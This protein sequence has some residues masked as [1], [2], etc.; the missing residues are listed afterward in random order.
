MSKFSPRL[1]RAVILAAGKS[2]RLTRLKL[3]TP[4]PLIRIAGK[5]LLGHHLERCHA[6][7][8]EE[9]FINLHYLPEQIRA[10]AGDG[11]RWKLK[12][13]YKEEVELLGTAG[14]VKNFSS[15]LQDEPF[16][17]IYG[18]NYCTFPL[19]ELIQAHFHS[20]PRP[21][22]SIV[23]FELENISGS[24]VA[25]CD[26]NN[27]IQSFIEKPVP[28]TTSSHWVNAGVY[29]MEPHLL[30]AIPDGA[31]DFGRDVIPAYLASG[32]RILGLKTQGRVHA[33]DTPELLLE[34]SAIPDSL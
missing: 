10:F 6:S 3:N 17:V 28:G 34:S 23:L 32:K 33:V 29:L 18:D 26:Q 31:C 4:K 22:M 21:D 7:G 27:L 1:R 8:I 15:S 16:L 19:D 9:V 20:S 24:G 14:G 25:V 12:I 2:E 30:E 5:P 11:S 13:S